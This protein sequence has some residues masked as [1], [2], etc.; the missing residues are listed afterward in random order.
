[1]IEYGE[2]SD[3]HAGKFDI[4]LPDDLELM[5]HRYASVKAA[6]IVIAKINRQLRKCNIHIPKPLGKVL[7]EK[8]TYGELGALSRVMHGA[9]DGH[10]ICSGCPHNDGDPTK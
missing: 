7:I 3:K 9:A 10:K 1:M 2:F 4:R 8:L 6:E 5:T